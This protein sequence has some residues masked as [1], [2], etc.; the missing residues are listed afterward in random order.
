MTKWLHLLFLVLD[1]VL[2][3]FNS[4]PLLLQFNLLF[5]YIFHHFKAD[6]RGI[7]WSQEDFYEF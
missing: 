6:Q 7:E 3:N 5:Y 2:T 4:L 1:V